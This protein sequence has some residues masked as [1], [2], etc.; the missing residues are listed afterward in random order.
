MTTRPIAWPAWVYGVFTPEAIGGHLAD[1]Y[2]FAKAA[3]R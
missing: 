3:A 1:A 2:E